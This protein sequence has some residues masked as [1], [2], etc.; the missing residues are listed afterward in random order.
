MEFHPRDRAQVWE[1]G[2]KILTRQ[3][4]TFIILSKSLNLFAYFLQHRMEI[5]T[6]PTLQVTVNTE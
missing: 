2:F 1:S 6:A 3:C 4:T 5:K